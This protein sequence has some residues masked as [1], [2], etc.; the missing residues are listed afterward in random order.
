[1]QLKECTSLEEVRTEIDM[2][3]DKIVELIGARNSYIKQAARFKNTVDEVKNPERIAEII[4]RV[5]HQALG[6]GM[7]ANLLEEIYTIMIN[8]MVESEIAEFR[9]S[10]VF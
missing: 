3:D 6:L 9:N 1:M 10:S 8:E 5:R 7:S 4:A 2:L